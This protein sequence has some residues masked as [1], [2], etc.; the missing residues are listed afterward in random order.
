[1]FSYFFAELLFVEGG[2]AGLPG[3]THRRVIPS[4]NP[5]LWLVGQFCFSRLQGSG[6][7]PSMCPNSCSAMVVNLEPDSPQVLQKKIV[8]LL[9][10]GVTVQASG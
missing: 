10:A 6:H 5:C 9:P 8:L 3:A 1:M 7:V 4:G 2:G